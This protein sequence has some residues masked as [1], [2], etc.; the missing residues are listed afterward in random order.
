MKQL[1]A[2]KGYVAP[3]PE[4]ATSTTTPVSEDVPAPPVSKKRK[5]EHTDG[6]REMRGPLGED[7][8]LPRT[9]FA[10]HLQE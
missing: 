8:H 9:S 4:E 1:S 5:T 3:P 10:Q 6:P 2:A 7:L